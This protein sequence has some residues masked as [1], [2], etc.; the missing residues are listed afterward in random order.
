MPRQQSDVLKGY[1]KGGSTIEEF[2]MVDLVDSL[3]CAFHRCTLAGSII[4]FYGL[5]NNP[6]YQIDLSSLIGSG[7][8]THAMLNGQMLEF[9]AS[10]VLVDVVNLNPLVAMLSTR[11]GDLETQVNGYSSSIQEIKDD[12]STINSDFS[13]IMTDHTTFTDRMDLMEDEFKKLPYFLEL[14]GN[15]V[16]MYDSFHTIV[17]SVDLSDLKPDLS[18]ITDRLDDAE[19][20][21][22]VLEG[23]TPDEL[24]E[25]LQYLGEIRDLVIEV[26]EGV[27]WEYDPS[28]TNLTIYIDMLVT[29]KSGW[30]NNDSGELYDFPFWVDV[31]GAPVGDIML[32]GKQLSNYGVNFSGWGNQAQITFKYG[33]KDWND[34]SYNF[35]HVSFRSYGELLD[36]LVNFK[37][38]PQDNIND[39][40][41]YSG[42][43]LLTTSEISIP[44]DY[45]FSTPYFDFNSNFFMYGTVTPMKRV[46]TMVNGYPSYWNN[47]PVSMQKQHFV[48]EVN[49]TS[50]NIQENVPSNGRAIQRITCQDGMYWRNV[51]FNFDGWGYT[52]TPDSSF[53]II[54][55][56]QADSNG[57]VRIGDPNVP[58]WVQLQDAPYPTYTSGNVSPLGIAI[59][60]DILNSTVLNAMNE[61]RR[62]LVSVLFDNPSGG[63]TQAFGE[64]THNP[65]EAQL[66][67][68]GQGTTFVHIGAGDSY[69][70][71]TA[72]S[73]SNQRF[74]IV[75]FSLD[76][77]QVPN[78][79]VPRSVRI[80]GS[81]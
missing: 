63:Q 45:T 75:L 27:A 43:R 25:V 81:F 1:F 70:W 62:L 34:P 61:G 55:I 40:R 69:I 56:S 48:L 19:G 47:A 20:R 28:T 57:W 73:A 68:S 65:E 24:G 76:G 10:G 77:T 23:N 80:W 72:L 8:F 54:G 58:Q 13:Q 22:D 18:D 26:G 4:T 59:N 74:R 37:D 31:V 49:I 6:E 32:R 79:L 9:Y 12:I 67:Y 38:S 7:S 51:S 64:H 11:V 21:L 46:C 30:Y 44:N 41:L 2:E 66:V 52:F 50:G 71:K 16:E 5:D 17:S 15:V 42:K 60:M 33:G 3:Q 78:T 36:W 29:K 35:S 53:G 39:V 14:N